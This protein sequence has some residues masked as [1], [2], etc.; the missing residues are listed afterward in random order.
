MHTTVYQFLR[1]VYHHEQYVIDHYARSSYAYAIILYGDQIVRRSFFIAPHSLTFRLA[2]L[3][4][5]SVVVQSN[6]QH[7]PATP[8]CSFLF[9]D[10]DPPAGA[11]K[12][13]IRTI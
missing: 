7:G 4:C 13:D 10:V 12:N 6:L 11:I 1:F 8:P 9:F 2:S 5:P 3:I